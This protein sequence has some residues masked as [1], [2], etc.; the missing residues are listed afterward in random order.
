[1][2]FVIKL[3]SARYIFLYESVG[4]DNTS[5]PHIY[6]AAF[7]RVGGGVL[8][9]VSDWGG[10]FLVFYDVGGQCGAQCYLVFFLYC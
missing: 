9:V 6:V 1:M 10:F 7:I 8:F 4:S 3:I 5:S 2:A